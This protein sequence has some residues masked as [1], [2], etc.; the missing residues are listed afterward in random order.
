[1]WDFSPF[2]K[3]SGLCPKPDPNMNLG[4]TSSIEDLNDPIPEL[5]DVLTEMEDEEKR[6]M[7]FTYPRHIDTLYFKPGNLNVDL[8][9]AIAI[10][11]K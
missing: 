11:K 4:K 9:Y 6:W 10:G 3:K 2:K 1:M 8:R 5:F 7:T